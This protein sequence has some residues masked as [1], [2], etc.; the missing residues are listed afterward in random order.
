MM[1]F[2]K[3]KHAGILP[4]LRHECAKKLTMWG[5]KRHNN[6]NQWITIQTFSSFNIMLTVCFKS[7][8][9][10]ASYKTSSLQARQNCQAIQ[11]L[12]FASGKDRFNIFLK[13]AGFAGDTDNA[14]AAPQRERAETAMPGSFA[15]AMGADAGE[16][17]ASMDR[18]RRQMARED[19]KP[20]CPLR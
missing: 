1:Q 19:T 3:T 20:S 7:K 12:Q 9:F 13:S 14:I 5:C 10:K 4:T 6:C 18:E 17:V 11:P 8:F 2:L 15:A 16:I